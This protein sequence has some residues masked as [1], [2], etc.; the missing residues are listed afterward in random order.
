MIHSGKKLPTSILWLF[1]VS[2]G[3]SGCVKD[4]RAVAELPEGETEVDGAMTSGMGDGGVAEDDGEVSE[5]DSEVQ[6]SDGSVLTV[7]DASEPEQ[8]A[9]TPESD[10]EVVEPPA[11][12]R[13]S[14]GVTD[15]EDNCPDLSN[16]DQV[17]EDE[18]GVGDLCELEPEADDDQDGRVNS[19]DNCPLVANNSQSDDDDDGLGNR[20][21]NC[22]DVANANQADSDGNGQGD[23]C[24]DR[25]DDGVLDG[26]DNCPDRD[27]PDQE[28]SDDDR[29]GNVCDNCPDTANNDQTDANGNGIGNACE[30]AAL[31]D[32]DLDGVADDVDNCPD[33]PNSEQN[34]GDDDGVGNACDNCPVVPNADQAP[35]GAAI[36]DACR[37]TRDADGDSV[38]DTQDNCVNRPNENQSDSDDD[39]VGDACDNCPDE[40]NFN[41]AD[42]DLDGRGDV[43]DPLTPQLVVELVWGIEGIDFDL[44]MVGPFDTFGSGGDCWSRN[45][46]FGWC[47][48]G[49][50][51]DYP[52]DDNAPAMY[53]Q[54]RVGDAVEGFHTVGV[55]RF[56]NDVNVAATVQVGIRCGD[57]MPVNF[58]PYLFGAPADQNRAFLEAVQVNPATCETIEIATYTTQT[59]AGGICS[60]VSCPAGAPCDIETGECTDLCD[61]ISCEDGDRCNPT[62]GECEVPI[63]DWGN[64]SW[65]D[66]P[67]CGDEDDCEVSE[68]CYRVPFTRATVCGIRCGDDNDA[69]CPANFFCCDYQDRNTP[70]YCVPEGEQL[71]QGFGCGNRN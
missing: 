5:T 1:C 56:P 52:V 48:P 25:D 34:D 42:A 24:A 2:L 50:Q 30:A 55:D 32:R 38:L 6:E 61:M 36:G 49:Y 58:G 60:P 66:A 51:Y 65:D 4:N 54:I 47:D 14:D 53:E 20:C 18:N 57:N 71:G 37:E 63:S 23:A 29:F 9:N 26:D 59:Q 31:E 41:Q 15:D 19:E 44:H 69:D 10:S 68:E 21:D 17:D 70:S 7:V 67:Y 33:S 46:R 35:E 16:A 40:A 62:S 11:G 43:C 27:N 13:D 3:L 8:D 22:P 45:R 12:D 64:G 28:N 39:G